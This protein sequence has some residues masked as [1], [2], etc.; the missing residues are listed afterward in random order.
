M[1]GLGLECFDARA[2]VVE[3]IRVVGL[4]TFDSSELL[5]VSLLR[6]EDSFQCFLDGIETPVDFHDVAGDE[7]KACVHALEF[8]PYRREF[9]V[10]ELIELFETDVRHRGRIISQEE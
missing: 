3:A 8:L 2:M 10:K 1:G 7:V 4:Q 5:R 9:L 6:V